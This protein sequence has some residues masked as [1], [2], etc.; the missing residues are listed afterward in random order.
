LTDPESVEARQVALAEISSDP[1]LSAVLEYWRGKA[2]EGGLPRPGDIDPTGLPPSVL[3]YL[4]ILDVI[5]GGDI[6]RVRL[7]GTASV[8]AAG[9]D[10]TGRYLDATMSGDVLA[11]ALERYR[12]AIAHRRPVLGYAEYKMADG[13][14]IRNLLMALPLS[15]DGLV[16]DR[17]LGVFGP[18]SD[19]L[20]QQALRN[21]DALASSKPKRSHVLL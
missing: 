20:A 10:F 9:R 18:R 11:A 7:V 8:S 5:D 1:K 4:T 13:S 2:R 14:T 16:V 17:I 19:W 6:F 12:A 3:P 15:S 21:L